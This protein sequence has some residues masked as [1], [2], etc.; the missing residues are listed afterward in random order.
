MTHVYVGLGANLGNPV[1]TLRSALRGLDR[2]P[3]SRCLAHSRFYRNPPMGPPGQP[4]Y[5]NAV[6][7]LD[8]RL[9]PHTLLHWLQT[10][11]RR[12]GRV[13]GRRWAARTLDLDLLI[14]GNLRLR[15]GRLRLPHPGVHRRAFVLYPLRELMPDIVIPGRGSASLWVRKC[16]SRDLKKLFN[17]PR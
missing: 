5:V 15:T 9:A 17:S 14:Y 1:A 3:G 2:L 10:I 13:R 6:A 4:D 16:P 8:T 7:R 12:H 11:E